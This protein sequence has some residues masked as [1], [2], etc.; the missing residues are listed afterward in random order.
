[1]QFKT[2]IAAF[3]GT[4]VGLITAESDV[5]WRKLLIAFTSGGFLYIGASSIIPSI[6]KNR[7]QG[8]VTQI[9]M[10]TCA[11]ALGVGIMVIVS[12]MEELSE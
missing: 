9:C 6:Q 5:A 3:V 10:E 11:F 12:V 7:G 4:F 8:N 2:S 1:M